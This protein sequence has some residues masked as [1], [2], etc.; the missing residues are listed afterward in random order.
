MISAKDPYVR[1]S[2]DVNGYKM[3]YV[4]SGTGDPIIFIHGNPTTSYEWRNVIPHLENSARCVAPDLIGMGASERLPDTGPD[5]YTLGDHIAYIDGFIESLGIKRNL[6]FVLDDW[7]VPIGLDWIRRHEDNVKGVTY[8]EGPLM[9]GSWASFAAKIDSLLPSGSEFFKAIR[10]VGLGEKLIMEDN[11]FIEKMLPEMMLRDLTSEELE[12]YGKHYLEG[13]ENRRALLSWPRQGSFDGEPAHSTAIFLRII[14]WLRESEIPKLFI[15]GDQ[16]T[17]V[18][19]ELLEFCQSLCNQK[20][21][22]V[23]GAHLLTEDSPH[24]IGRAIK[25]WYQTL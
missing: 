21:L 6:T 12:Q 25:D 13:G 10:T 22:T 19:G 4:D 24:E 17:L 7:G 23:R 18:T 11:L 8:F 20:E 16:S 15:R 9:P 14:D 5:S 3:A 2:V 1:K